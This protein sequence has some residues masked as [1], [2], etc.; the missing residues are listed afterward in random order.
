MDKILLINACVRPGS[1]TRQ[2]AES[3]LKKLDGTVEEVCLDRINL[4]ALGPEGIEKR[5]QA[6]QNGDFSD[7]EFDLAKQFASAD[8]IVV[9]AP[10]WDL[11]F[12]GVLKLYLENITVAGITFRYTSD[13][14][15]ESLCCAKALDYVTTSGGYIGQNDFG[16]SYLSALAKNFFGIRKIRRY[17][18]EGLDIWGA[19]PN[20]I[21]SQAKAA[22]E[23]DSDLHIIPYPEK[24]GI[25]AMSGAASIQGA[26]NHV[27]SRYYVSN[28]FFHMKSDATLHILNQF[29]TYQQTTEYTCGAASALMVLNWFGQTRYH[30]KAV[31]GLLETHCTRGS[32][33][34]NIA[35]LF[36][37]I[38]WN[39][40]YHASV[41]PKFQTVEEAEQAIIRYI[42]RGIPIMVD[43]V[44]W[45]GH[46]QVLIGIDTCGTDTPYDDV[47]IFADPYDVTDH[48]Q[49]GYY[50]FPLG[51][52][53]G[54]WREGPCA[55][56]IKPYQQPFVAAWPSP[57]GK[58]F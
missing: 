3:V 8:H 57:S 2:L 53:F 31:A 14:K 12:P 54:M 11:M 52:F 39:V 32:S 40:E 4:T 18:A 46:W 29:K 24:Y 34:E 17:T 23:T 33:V 37:L 13:G 26:A 30:E 20:K 7:P 41:D 21:L 44:D 22:A 38:G 50:T 43:W 6:S 35:D 56:K 51:R 25:P 45:A 5:E 55:E 49:D 48:N 9:A 1:R 10:Y 36:D 27:Q 58:D 16:F 19:D 42:D 47:L 15:P 28:D